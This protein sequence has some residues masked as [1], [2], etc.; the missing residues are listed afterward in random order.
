MFIRKV[1]ILIS[2][3]MIVL[4]EFDNLMCFDLIDDDLIDGFDLDRDSRIVEMRFNI[5]RRRYSNLID[6]DHCLCYVPE[7]GI[8]HG[9]DLNRYL[10]RFV[11]EAN[12]YVCSKSDFGKNATLLIDC[13]RTIGCYYQAKLFPQCRCSSREIK[14]KTIKCGRSLSKYCPKDL[15]FLCTSERPKLIGVC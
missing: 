7:P 2:T 13:S 3:I 9:I 4:F 5:F 10:N 6:L 14:K 15:K 11:C 1:Q 12:I 8:Y